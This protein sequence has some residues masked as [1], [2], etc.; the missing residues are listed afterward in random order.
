M[1]ILQLLLRASIAVMPLMSAALT[2]EDAPD[3]D[4]EESVFLPPNRPDK[5]R[6]YWLPPLGSAIIPGF[7]QFQEEQYPY[8]A[9]Y[10]GTTLA[11]FGYAGYHGAKLIEE[12]E[13]SNYDNWSDEEKDSQEIH[14]E[15]ERKIMYGAQFWTAMGGLSSYHSFRTAVA[16][17]K[18]HG[19]FAFLNKEESIGDLLLAPFNMTYL[20]RP[21]TWIPLGA[22]AAI[23][24]M[25]SQEMK[26]KYD[27]RDDPDAKPD[28]FTASDAFFA[29]GISY[30]AGVGE[31]A[32]FRG[33]IMPALMES[34][35][36]PFWSNTATAAVFALAHLGTVDA[37]VAQFLLGWHLG[38]TS[39]RNE[40]TLGESIFIHAWWDVIVLATTYSFREITPENPAPPVWFPPF[41]VVW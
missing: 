11:G 17:N 36:S 19:Q 27:K 32:M 12:R 4:A 33:W 6:N 38:W 18:P 23:S 16:V 25:A 20:A 21:T 1:K 13:D 37:P 15:R 35:Q 7:D 29:S 28:P 34:W 41:T 10:L 2:A 9:S 3:F 31:E 40:W 14:G 8:A 5:P 22:A 39:Q 26:R 24:V 30:N